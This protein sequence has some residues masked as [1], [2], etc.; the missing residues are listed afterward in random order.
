[1]TY[2]FTDMTEEEAEIFMAGNAHPIREL[3]AERVGSRKIIDFGCGR[4]IGI[5]D[6][7]MKEQYIGLDCSEEL[8][9]I[10]K[11]DNPDYHFTSIEL[12]HALSNIVD[13]TYEVGIMV[14]VLEHVPSLSLA[15][16]IYQEARR[17]CRDLY[18]GWHCAPHYPETKIIQVQ[19]ELDNLMYQNHYAEGS[20]HGIRRVEKI[21]LAE[22][23][24][25]DC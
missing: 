4:G 24:T 16:S 25:V 21:A 23:W 5:K 10:A 7:Y 9:K 18:V 12:P 20:F 8:I 11:R 15:Q 22:L 1:M 13:D 3:V 19:A 2:P 6:L 17:V 14:S